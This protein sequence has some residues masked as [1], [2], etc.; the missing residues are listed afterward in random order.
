M[1]QRS[2]NIHPGCG[3]GAYEWALAALRDD[4][5]VAWGML[6]LDVR[7]DRHMI[8]RPGDGAITIWVT[9]RKAAAA[10]S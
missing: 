6:R 1:T 3:P 7:P 9:P 8:S 10:G 2:L 5:R 4:T